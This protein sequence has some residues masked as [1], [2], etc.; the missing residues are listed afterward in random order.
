[1]NSPTRSGKPSLVHDYCTWK[2]QEDRRQKNLRYHQTH[3][4]AGA[5]A[6]FRFGVLVEVGD[7]SGPFPIPKAW[8]G[9]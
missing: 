3:P 2:Y 8:L 1:M 5:W 6:N 7:N 9:N 4:Q